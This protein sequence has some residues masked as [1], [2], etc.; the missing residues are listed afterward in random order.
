MAAFRRL[1]QIASIVIDALKFVI[2]QI[3]KQTPTT[4]IKTDD[5]PKNV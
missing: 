4:K 2:E 3:E 5:K 1:L